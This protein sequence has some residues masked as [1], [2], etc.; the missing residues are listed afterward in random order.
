MTKPA[1]CRSPIVVPAQA[2]TH[3]SSY[4][5]TAKWIPAFAGITISAL[6]NDDP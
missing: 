1:Y 6:F 5:V 4:R 3:I 2:G